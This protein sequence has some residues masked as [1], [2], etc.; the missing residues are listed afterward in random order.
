MGIPTQLPEILYSPIGRATP[1]SLSDGGPLPLELEK[2]STPSL[3]LPGNSVPRIAPHWNEPSTAEA[4]GAPKLNPEPDDSPI[5]RVAAVGPEPTV[6]R[7]P[8]RMPPLTKPPISREQGHP[9][10]DPAEKGNPIHPDRSLPAASP[11]KPVV[12]PSRS[13]EAAS[14]SGSKD[15]EAIAD[16]GASLGLAWKGIESA[17]TAE[18]MEL[19]RHHPGRS[20]TREGISPPRPTPSQPFRI[21]SRQSSASR[22]DASILRKSARKD[23]GA[24]KSIAQPPAVT[25]TAELSPSGGNQ[26]KASIQHTEADPLRPTSTPS[27]WRGKEKPAAPPVNTPT[28]PEATFPRSGRSGPAIAPPSVADRPNSQKNGT[29]I[30]IGRIEVQVNNHSEPVAAGRSTAQPAGREINLE[31]RFLGRFVLRPT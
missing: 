2:V 13:I 29:R 1:E 9:T 12:S 26:G 27:D 7:D 31:S 23:V 15:S 6:P 16:P 25:A 11:P 21:N 22:L 10:V 17:A 24:T 30:A 4:S 18:P 8:Q 3:I 19:S 20:E 14:K 28:M 5:L